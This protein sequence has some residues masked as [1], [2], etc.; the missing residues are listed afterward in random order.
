MNSESRRA[1]APTGSTP[2]GRGSARTGWLVRSLAVLLA[3][4]VLAPPAVRAA[5]DAPAAAPAPAPAA[6]FSGD[7]A[8]QHVRHLA[9]T[10]G[11]R[12][13]G[14]DREAEAARY[15]AGELTRYGYQT[16]TQPFSITTYDER[17]AT[18]VTLSPRG[19]PIETSALVYSAAGDVA[20]EL[21]DAGYGREGDWAPGA[22]AGHVALLERGEITFSDKVAN[23]AAAG[24]TAA[25]I[26]NNREA[27]YSGNLSG[28]SP[29]PAVTLLG[30]EGQALREQLQNGPVRV[31]VTV[32]AETVTRQSRNVIGMRPGR[33]PEAI[34]IG[35]HFDSVPA[36]PGANDNASGTA[37]VLEL[38][39]YFAQRDYPYTLYFVAFGAEEIG[40]R[41]SRHFVEA[42]P[43]SARSG[44]R[45]MINLDMVG[46]GDQERFSGAAELVDMASGV[47]DAIGFA[48]YTTNAGSAGG[49]SDHA[50][51]DRA[52]VPVLF[53]YRSNDPNYHSPRD[54]AEFV[55]PDALA[56]AGRLAA[57]V[58]D[59]LA[60]ETQ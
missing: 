4:L 15:L 23:V 5:D 60:A 52:G 31:G 39:R 33:R 22:L 17:G 24:A 32:D 13:T 1:G 12:P 59:R 37:T 50:S 8:Y 48:D 35:A 26:F 25:I 53:I 2:Q 42:L 55:D 34:I 10:I 3:L 7:E 46:V 21:V 47:A 54:R 19:A 16:E 18:V 9:D 51:F 11:S 6:A 56:L 58:L 38:A 49:G 20:G 57:G 14:T 29:I 43:E 27:S 45:A 40:L 44:L 36:G 28:E 30:S 41:G